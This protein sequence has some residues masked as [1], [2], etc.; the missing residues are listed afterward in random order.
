MCTFEQLAVQHLNVYITVIG[1]VWL[2][3]GLGSSECVS[4]CLGSLQL[5]Q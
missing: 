1:S 3:L 4:G 5:S 2:F